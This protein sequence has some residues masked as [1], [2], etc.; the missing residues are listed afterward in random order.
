MTRGPGFGAVT[1][2]IKNCDDMKATVYMIL[3]SPIN[4]QTHSHII[5]LSIFYCP[6][7]DLFLGVLLLV[8]LRPS[9]PM[10]LLVRTLLGFLFTVRVGI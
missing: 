7:T 3:C 8:I 2:M 1:V 5:V 6:I 4:N 9:L 10:G